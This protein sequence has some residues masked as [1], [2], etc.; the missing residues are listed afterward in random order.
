[1]PPHHRINI[2]NPLQQ[3]LG[4]VGLEELLDEKFKQ[5][6]SGYPRLKHKVLK[7]VYISVSGID[8]LPRRVASG[9]QRDVTVS[10]SLDAPPG[11]KP[12][13]GRKSPPRQPELIRLS[14][15]ARHD[16][17]GSTKVKVVVV[18]E[19]WVGPVDGAAL[20]L[21]VGGSHPSEARGER[22]ERSG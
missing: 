20:V 2:R 14:P 6:L 10:A 18:D 13:N 5:L 1:V 22:S 4:K 9:V 11:S 3:L 15:E 17:M 21:P 19:L 12:S 16:G 8:K 7:A